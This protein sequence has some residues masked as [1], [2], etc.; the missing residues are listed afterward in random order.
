MIKW[1]SQHSF[2]VFWLSII[3]LLISDILS[4]IWTNPTIHPIPYPYPLY[5]SDPTPSPY[6]HWTWFSWHD[7]FII[8]SPLVSVMNL[9]SSQYYHFSSHLSSLLGSYHFLIH[10]YGDF[11][12][13]IKIANPYPII[14]VNMSK[15]PPSY[16]DHNCLTYWSNQIPLSIS[17]PWLCA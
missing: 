2:I 1:Y 12:G 8:R 16:S 10:F 9:L 14:K 5:N 7:T 15:E 6:Y 3:S 4:I 17:I 13:I 11:S